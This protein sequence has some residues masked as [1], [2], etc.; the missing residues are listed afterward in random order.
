MLSDQFT[1]GQ[2]IVG[3]EASRSAF[4]TVVESARDAIRFFDSDGI[5]YG[6][7]R[8]AVATAMRQFLMASPATR[9]TIIVH[10]TTFIEKSCPRLMSLLKTFAPRMQIRQSNDDVRHFDRGFLIADTVAVLRRPSFQQNFSILDYE[11]EQVS[12]ASALFNQLLSQSDA[13]PAGVVTGL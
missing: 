8:L 2:R 7:D 12:T 13:G 4:D 1:G 9:L 11:E 3:R 5:F 10:Q 6:L